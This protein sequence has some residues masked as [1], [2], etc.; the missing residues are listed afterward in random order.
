M[1]AFRTGVDRFQN[2][3]MVGLRPFDK[4]GDLW[5]FGYGLGT[6]KRLTEK[7]RLGFDW[8]EQNFQIPNQGISL[9]LLTK[10]AL[11]VE[12]RPHRYFNVVAGPTFNALLADIWSGNDNASAVFTRI[13]TTP[14][15]TI[16]YD[17]VVMR[18]WI[19]WKVAVRFL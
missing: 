2:I 6:S 15:S 18:M 9:N 19:G 17:Y 5:T 16:T 13:H 14:L 11:S 12:W 8:T 7:W 1:F 4:Y 3:F 10:A